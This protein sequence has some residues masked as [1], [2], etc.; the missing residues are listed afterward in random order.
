MEK[1][2][3]DTHFGQSVE[4][5][6]IMDGT[7]KS[8][9]LVY[10]MIPFVDRARMIQSTIDS[11][12]TDGEYLPYNEHL[13]LNYQLIRYFTDIEFPE[14]EIEH[15]EDESDEDF[16]ARKKNAEISIV[17]E[18]I[19][20]TNV[21]NVLQTIIVDYE[22]L[23]AEIH[24]GVEHAKQRTLRH[25]TWD[26]VG[27]KFAALLQTASDLIAETDTTELLSSLGLDLSALTQ[28]SADE[29]SA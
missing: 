28:A 16:A 29:V 14:V 23:V 21:I 7:S 19:Q 18:F 4:K 26:D 27:A 12:V 15:L 22:D 1:F 8:T 25:S 5:K 20:R 24:A 2:T 6:L 13:A 17:F 10:P 11:I 3:F 9:F